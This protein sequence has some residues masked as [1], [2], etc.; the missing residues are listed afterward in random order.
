M[1]RKVLFYSLGKIK[2]Y[3]EKNNYEGFDPYDGL[4]S[5]IFRLPVFRSNKIIRFGA[6]QFVKRLPINIRPFLFIQK[7]RNPVTIGLSLQAYSYLYKNND[8]SRNDYLDKIK[9]LINELEQM[10]CKG[11]S[12]SCWGYDFDWEARYAKIKA[13]RPTVVATAIITNALF[14]AYK[15]VNIKKAKKLV[16]SA[17]EFVLND[18]NIIFENDCICFSYSPYDKQK[19]FNASIKGARILIQAYSLSGN[20][21]YLKYATKA[22][23]FV[24]NNQALNGSWYYSLNKNGNWVDNYH[25]GYILD[26]LYE[27]QTLSNDHSFNDNLLSGYTFYKSNFITK[28]GIPKFY[29]NKIF[30]IDC[31]AASQFILTLTKFGDFDIAMKVSEWMISNMQKK[32]G[33]FKFRKYKYFSINTSFMRWSNA[34]MLA[35]FSYLY[36]R[37]NESNVK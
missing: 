22:V 3:I 16:I 4:T 1:G 18:L 30:P 26:C 2:E 5:P 14:L 13:N 15:V 34:W 11:F 31:T 6:Q 10:S 32:N 29:H 7:G 27:Y 25:T 21:D 17:A 20:E 33:S 9:F 37:L 19:V 36:C 23:K 28:D 24:I 35:S 8:I 12:N